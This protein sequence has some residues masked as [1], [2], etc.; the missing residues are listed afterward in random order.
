MRS[1][2]SGEFVGIIGQPRG[3]FDS[4]ADAAPIERT[5]LFLC[6]NAS[7]QASQHRFARRGPTG[8]VIEIRQDLEVLSNIGIQ[9]S[10][11]MI[12]HPVAEQHHLHVQ[13]DGIRF[14]RNSRCPPDEP[15]D[16]LDR[17]FLA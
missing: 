3:M 14:K 8:L 17:N 2:S 9:R 6:G 13:R 12:E 7:D 15:G 11:Q 16:I 10:Q 5:K 4:P 1:T